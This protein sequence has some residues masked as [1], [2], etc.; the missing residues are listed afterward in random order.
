MKCQGMF[1]LRPCGDDVA[2]LRNSAFK[3]HIQLK[4]SAAF[5]TYLS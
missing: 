3:F 1:V 4:Q 2:E 5:G